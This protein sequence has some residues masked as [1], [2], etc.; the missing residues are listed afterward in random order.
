MSSITVPKFGICYSSY[1][2]ATEL[3]KNSDWKSNL[4]SIPKKHKNKNT[5]LE[6][7][8]HSVVLLPTDNGHKLSTKSILT[9]LKEK[10]NYLKLCGISLRGDLKLTKKSQIRYLE[11]EECETEE[12]QHQVLAK[13]IGSCHSLEK[14]S[15]RHMQLHSNVIKTLCIQ[16]G[17]TLQSLDLSKFYI[18]NTDSL[19][20]ITNYCV[21][22]KELSV[23]N[24]YL[25]GNE[26]LYLVN[27]LQPKIEKLNLAVLPITN[28]HIEALVTR[29]NQIKE[30]NLN[31]SG[32][33]T[34]IAVNSIMN[35]LRD[36]LETLNLSGCRQIS[37]SKLL[38][39]KSMPQLKHLKIS[40]KDEELERL[41]NKFSSLKIYQA[42]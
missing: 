3:F 42:K 24:T 39:L 13:L 4:T 15:L 32:P 27:N 20:H 7:T 16:N 30:L 31:H 22:L 21:N 17:Q 10:C 25:S 14:L 11:V 38:E 12:F 19:W 36:T 9:I 23:E 29:C 1:K 5:Y 33:I 18:L 2:M 26:T 8:D 35:N 28:G 41:Q 34:D 40:C 6:F 37:R